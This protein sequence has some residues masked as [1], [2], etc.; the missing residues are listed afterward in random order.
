[1]ILTPFSSLLAG[2]I[3]YTP[4]VGPNGQPKRFLGNWETNLRSKWS[5]RSPVVTSQLYISV[6]I[7][8]GSYLLGKFEFYGFLL[9][10]APAE[11]ECNPL[12]ME[13]GKISDSQLESLRYKDTSTHYSHLS[14]RYVT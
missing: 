8:S 14:A 1:M 4:T 5:F 10:I 7:G 6:E 11:Y 2:C 12:G 9:E 3:G 13:S